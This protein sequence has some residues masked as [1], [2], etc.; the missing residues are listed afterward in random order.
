MRAAAS[1]AP[2]PSVHSYRTLATEHEALMQKHLHLLQIVETEKTVARQLRQQIEDGEV[3][4]ER[5]K[6]E[7]TQAPC[8][9]PPAPAPCRSGGTRQAGGLLPAAATPASR[10]QVRGAGGWG[11]PA[12]RSGCRPRLCT[13]ELLPEQPPNLSV[14]PLL[15]GFLFLTPKA[16]RIGR[17]AYGHIPSTL[18]KQSPLSARDSGGTGSQ[19]CHWRGGSLLSS[20]QSLSPPGRMGAPRGLAGRGSPGQAFESFAAPERGLAPMPRLLSRQLGTASAPGL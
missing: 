2:C 9:A 4:I 18:T 11:R 1:H 8:P 3:E 13:P 20:K 6:A 17:G 16:V 10:F 19:V 12:A 15:P 5:L 14:L 7:V